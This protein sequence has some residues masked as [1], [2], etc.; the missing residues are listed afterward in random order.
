MQLGGIDRQAEEREKKRMKRKA[1]EEKRIEKER[2][3]V[4]SIAST[5]RAPLIPVNNGDEERNMRPKSFRPNY[6][7]AEIFSDDE[8]GEEEEE[9]NEDQPYDPKIRT[10]PTHV[11]FEVEVDSFLE[12]TSNIS[13]RRNFS[14]RARSDVVTNWAQQGGVA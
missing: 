11:K 13:D 12:S 9:E 10:R 1:E 2:E 7:H 8:E 6:A 14:T 5:S 3:R 4:A